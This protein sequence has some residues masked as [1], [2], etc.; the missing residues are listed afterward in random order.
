MLL[1]A[2]QPFF[3]NR[4]TPIAVRM[5]LEFF[6]RRGW[7]TDAV[8]LDGGEKVDIPGVRFFRVSRP[9][10]VRQVRPGFSLAKLICDVALFLQTI[11]LVRD[12]RYD[13]VH[14]V[15][16]ASFIGLRVSHRRGRVLLRLSR[17]CSR[18]GRRGHPQ[19]RRG[20]VPLPLC[21]LRT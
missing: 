11:K 2:P 17:R 6:S 5:L 16:E 20:L 13:Y 15:E 18:P 19:P 4:G 12:E 9:P 21:V 8:V 1:L 3:Q 14:C 10:F 7:K